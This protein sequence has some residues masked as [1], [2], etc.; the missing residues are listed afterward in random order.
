L[1]PSGISPG[2]GV[3]LG[4]PDPA[5]ELAVAEGAESLLSAMRLLG[6]ADGCAALS[7]LGVR[8]LILPPAARRVCIFADRDSQ[9][10]GMEAARGAWLRWRTEGR[11]VRVVQSERPGEDANDVWMRLSH[12]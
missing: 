3:W 5:R 7:T 2:G 8:E 12:G 6:V 9:G 4:E 11:E 10:Q 1:F